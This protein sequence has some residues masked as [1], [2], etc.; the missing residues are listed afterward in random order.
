MDKYYPGNWTPIGPV[1]NDQGRCTF[2]YS[3]CPDGVGD[4]VPIRG[5][6]ERCI[7][8]N[9]GIYSR[10]IDIVDNIPIANLPP[11]YR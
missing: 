6:R 2:Y 1:F 5:I 10:Y 9:E 4:R 11:E 3:P 8:K 7:I